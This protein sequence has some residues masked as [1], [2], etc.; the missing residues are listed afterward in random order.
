MIRNDRDSSSLS[1]GTNLF[2]SKNMEE[3]YLATKKLVNLVKHIP[4]GKSAYLSWLFEKDKVIKEVEDV[5]DKF[6]VKKLKKEK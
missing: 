4:H 1:S 5:I 2:K 6:V 3:L